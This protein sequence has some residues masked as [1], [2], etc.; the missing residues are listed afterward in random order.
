MEQSFSWETHGCSIIRDTSR[1]SWRLYI[2]VLTKSRH[3][4]LSWAK[5]IQSTTSNN[6]SFRFTLILYFHLRLRIP[7]G[8]FLSGFLTKIAYAFL[9]T[10][11]GYC[12]QYTDKVMGWT[13]GVRFPAGPGNFCLRHRIHTGFEAHP[14]SY[15]I[16]NKDSFPGGKAPGA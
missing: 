12:S 14:A 9:S 7:N 1:L 16:G 3:W 5:W 13:T 8:L 4:T 11:M 15:P 2:T 10:E 6:T